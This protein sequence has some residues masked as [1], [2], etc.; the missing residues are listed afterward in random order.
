MVDS[1]AWTGAL[2]AVMVW[3]RNSSVDY[4]L[5]ACRHCKN[6]STFTA[7]VSFEDINTYQLQPVH[8]LIGGLKCTTYILQIYL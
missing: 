4:V 2:V 5:S 3:V 8:G 1:T 6:I 7:T